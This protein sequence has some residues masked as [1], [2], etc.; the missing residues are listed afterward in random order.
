RPGAVRHAVAQLAHEVRAPAVGGAGRVDGASMLAPGRHGPE[1]QPARDG[2][3]NVRRPVTP[4]QLTT[5]PLT[6]AAAPPRGRD[7]AGAGSGITASRA[8]RREGQDARDGDRG[9]A[10]DVRVVAQLAPVVQPPTVRRAARADRAGVVMARTDGRERD[11]S[12]HP[13]RGGR[14]DR[15]RAIAQLAL[16]YSAP[17][18]RGLIRRDAARVADPGTHRGEYQA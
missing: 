13:D 11:I 2:T 3:R 14:K 15:G 1:A 4:A 18:V 12:G 17:A 9:G 16:R 8:D 7:R 5:Q 10:V 6:P